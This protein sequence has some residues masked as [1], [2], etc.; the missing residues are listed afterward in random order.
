MAN[1]V[2]KQVK[3]CGRSLSLKNK[4]HKAELQSIQTTH[5]MELVC[6]DFLTVESRRGT[7]R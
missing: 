4:P 5:P 2:T 7:R 6:L 3:S 1:D